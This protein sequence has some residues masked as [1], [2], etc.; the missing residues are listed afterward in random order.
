MLVGSK[1]TGPPFFLILC[2]FYFKN[3]LKYLDWKKFIAFF[4]PFTIFGLSWYIRNY[5]LTGDPF[6]PQPFLIFKGGHYAILAVNVWKAVFLYPNGILKMFSAFLSE[7]TIWF[8][9][10]F[11]PIILVFKNV[12]KNKNY[13]I[14]LK[15]SLIG[16][17]NFF[18]FWF[19]PSN[20]YYDIMVSVFRYT[21]P[22]LIPLILCIFIF[23]KNYGKDEL[24]S[25]IAL[26]NLLIIPEIS[27]HPK[28][29]IFYIPIAL[30][31]YYY[32][33]KD[34]IYLFS[35]IKFFKK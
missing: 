2:F 22:S 26:I 29:L 5:L 23:F 14:L 9:A 6:Y 3:L 20:K 33:K 27:Y 18:V 31:I 25:I 28:I 7:Y 1:Y 15:L 12:K 17:L 30:F 34:L 13:K 35:K 24:I 32:N 4:I 21:Y 10:I 8:L 19:L 11:F 16:W